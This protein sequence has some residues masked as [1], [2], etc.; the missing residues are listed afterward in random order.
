LNSGFH[1]IPIEK[2]GRLFVTSRPRGGDWIEDEVRAW[3]M[4]GVDVVV[5]LLEPGEIGEF[6]LGNEKSALRAAGIEFIL[7]PIPDCGVPASR[8]AFAE[9]ISQLASKLDT[10]KTI[11]IHCRQGIGRAGLVAS[12]LLVQTGIAVREAIRRVSEARG[13]PIPE[14][15]EQRQ[16]ILDYASALPPTLSPPAQTGMPPQIASSPLRKNQ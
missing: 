6:D 16:W 12:A 10:G 11:V 15:A 8:A 4:D 9:L 14:T 7:F 5:S 13:C 3:R 2:A 1:R